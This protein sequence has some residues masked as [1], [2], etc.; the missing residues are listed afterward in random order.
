MLGYP[1]LLKLH[2]GYLVLGKVEPLA[3]STQYE[4]HGMTC[5]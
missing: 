3:G 1:A 4:N 2:A 5:V